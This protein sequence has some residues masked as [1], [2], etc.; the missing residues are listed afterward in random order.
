MEYRRICT[1]PTPSYEL[2]S[3]SLAIPVNAKARRDE[4]AG[5]YF[6]RP[7]A[8]RG[9]PPSTSRSVPSSVQ[10][11]VGSLG[12][13]GA[14]TF[15]GNGPLEHTPPRESAQSL[16][17]R[18]FPPLH[19]RGVTA[20]TRAC[21]RETRATAKTKRG[22]TGSGCKRPHANSLRFWRARRSDG[23]RGRVMIFMLETQS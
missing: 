21:F 8:A 4:G 15:R 9:A 18:R 22:V 7:S 14:S 23:F 1:E 20:G 17:L 6:G 10:T 2:G 3:A 11:R 5:A 13:R 12:T 19:P 16:R